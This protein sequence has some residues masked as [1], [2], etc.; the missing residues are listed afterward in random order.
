MAAL[1]IILIPFS[2]LYSFAIYL[3]NK[4]YD[5]GIFKSIKISKPVISIGNI[6][7]G[8]TG[9]T[10]FTIFTAKHYLR[11]GKT[12][13]II[14]RGYK[15]KSKDIFIVS[16]GN[17]INENA[18]QSGDELI[19]ISK[20]LIKNFKGK[21]FTAAGADRI[22][23]S[24]ELINTFNPDI[25]IL[26][27]AFQHRKIFRD[28]DIV[29][30]DAEDFNNSKFPDNLSLPSGK[31]RE[32]IS[33]YSRAD[34]IIQNNKASEIKLLSGLTAYKK[35]LITMRYNTEY[36][37]DNKNCILQ[38]ANYDAVIFSGIAND[39]SFIRMN[40]TSGIRINEAVKFSD[41]YNYKLKDIEYL[42][43]K[44]SG[45]KIFITTE[46]DFVKIRQ[47]ENFVKDYPVYFLKMGI[48]ITGNRNVLTRKLDEL[49]K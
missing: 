36:F 24:N 13:G 44:Y 33:G 25:I 40:K 41:H 48:E 23:A 37:M 34:L 12:V 3:R 9:K 45:N 42:K 46:K 14:A 15:R 38:K 19:L 17:E 4:F 1:K 10:P 28:I 21:F 22:K 7:A 8:G 27:D 30:L 39:E 35:D 2:L 43:K 49:I 16:N 26:D 11:K 5:A 31:M 6:T 18:S 29:L 47:F 20:E 32:S